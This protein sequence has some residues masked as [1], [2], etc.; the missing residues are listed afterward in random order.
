MRSPPRI[1]SETCPE[2]YKK[3]SCADLH[4]HTV[5]CVQWQKQ[6]GAP[7]PK[8]KFSRTP[9]FYAPESVE[10]TDYVQ[11][12]VCASV[13]WDL[14][15]RRLIQHLAIHGLTEA[16]YAAV[17]PGA[18]VRLQTTTDRR[19]AT[20]LAIYGV[21]NVS[22]SVEVRTKIGDTIQEKYGARCSLQNESVKERAKASLRSRY[23]VDN[24][25][26]SLEVQ[27]KIKKSNLDR[28]GVENPMQSPEVRAKAA[29]TCR[30]KYGFDTFLQTDDFKEKAAVTS[31]ARY[32]TDHPMKAPEVKRKVSDAFQALYGVENVLLLPEVWRRTYETNISN[33]GGVHSQSRP[34]VL[35]KA[36]ETWLEKYGV[37]NP[38][39]VPEVLAR[40]RDVWASKYGVPFPPQS[41]HF[42]RGEPNGLERAVGDISP[43]NVVYS[44]NAAFW[45]RAPEGG[46][47]RNPDFVV[48]TDEQLKA[49]QNGASLRTHTVTKVIEAFGCYWHGPK[50]TGKS[51]T[52]HESEVVSFYADAGITCLVL[53]ENDVKKKPGDTASRIQ[54]FLGPA[55]PV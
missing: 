34:E 29:S 22:K 16:D 37:D 9:A 19:R 49:W 1:G 3:I 50:F 46:K 52:E 18:P 51:R 15:F 20:T 7:W 40:I 47:T 35:A 2:C 27:A 23:G 5:S 43:V 32:G 54:A 41:L 33:H 12:R 24:A 25:F 21:D 45:V 4:G 10:G 42:S 36:R 31:R 8:F 48:L 13:G 6:R 39:K 14:R 38:S 30:D 28:L 26:A 53:W 17:Y 44:G 55:I 11:C